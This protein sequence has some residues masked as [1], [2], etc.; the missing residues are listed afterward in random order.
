MKE[1]ERMQLDAARS[2]IGAK[3]GT[4][5]NAIFQELG[6]PT[7][8]SRRNIHKM[9]KMYNIVN[10]AVPAYLKSIF[11]M[12][13]LPGEMATRAQ[14][15]R[16][17]LIPKC[18]TA[19]YK[20][21]FTVSGMLAWNQLDPNFRNLS[22]LSF[23][24]T[25]MK[26]YYSVAHLPFNNSAS[27]KTQIIFSQIRMGFSDLKHHLFTKGCTESG[28]CKCGALKEDTIHFLLHCRLYND[29]Q[30]VMLRNI[31]D[32]CT[33][34][35]PSAA[36]CLFGSDQLSHEQNMSIFSQVYHYIEESKRFD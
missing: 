21:S 6:W 22:S 31:K 34:I 30:S 26:S 28:K 4:S 11:T 19:H 33:N 7:L 29:T 24:K 14:L 25:R 12:Y 35:K 18:K 32:I 23:F 3:R 27:R 1:I 10:N 9:C 16:C 20:S 17:F 36:L 8:R 2:V 13:Q 5:T 15:N